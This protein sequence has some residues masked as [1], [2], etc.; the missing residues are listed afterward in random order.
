MWR[1]KQSVWE[2]QKGKERVSSIFGV[3]GFYSGQWSS[4][5]VLSGI[6]ELIRTQTLSVIP[7]SQGVLASRCLTLV[8]QYTY[9]DFA[10]SFPVGSSLDV[11]YPKE[12]I[13]SLPLTRRTHT[14][15]ILRHVSSRV[16]VQ[17]LARLESRKRNKKQISME[18]FSSPVSV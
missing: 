18:S 15:C 10:C 4:T 6:Q 13:N 7:W 3:W 1:Y 2:T 12:I 11:I 14:I 9:D 16:G 17:V 5:C 8:I